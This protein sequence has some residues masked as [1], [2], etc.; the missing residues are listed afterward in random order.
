MDQG[1]LRRT[2]TGIPG[3][4]NILCG[5]FASNRLYLIDGSPGVGKTTL[6]MQFLIDGVRAGERCLYVTLSETRD[7]TEAVVLTQR[8]RV[9]P[10]QL[11]GD[12]DHEARGS[13]HSA[14]RWLG[15]SLELASPLTA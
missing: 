6:A 12:R 8:L 14:V 1:E 13:S 3:L 2:S 4:D 9:H 7:E 10:R 15:R 5:G 11:R